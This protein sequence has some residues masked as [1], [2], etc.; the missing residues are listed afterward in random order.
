VLL[1]HLLPLR[2]LRSRL[3]RLPLRLKYLLRSL[4]QLQ[5]LWPPPQLLQ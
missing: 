3:Q 2:L 4:H 1:P 5:R